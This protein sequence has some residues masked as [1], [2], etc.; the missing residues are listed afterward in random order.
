M[1]QSNTDRLLG[2]LL[3]EMRE[4]NRLLRMLAKETEPVAPEKTPAF[5]AMTGTLKS[6]KPRADVQ[7][8]E[9]VEPVEPG[10]RLT[11]EQVRAFQGVGNGQR[12]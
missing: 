7:P 1:N 10:I 8:F 11:P 6:D 2:K 5:A 4:T 9:P 3:G 12:R